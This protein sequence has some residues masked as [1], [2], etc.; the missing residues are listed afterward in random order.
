M[1]DFYL[2]EKLEE[3]YGL[4]FHLN[5]ENKK[6]LKYACE[7]CKL[8]N[9]DLKLLPKLVPRIVRRKVEI[10]KYKNN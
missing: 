8:I 9:R 2:I 7:W 6:R 5:L 1:I 10:K 3:L 4:P